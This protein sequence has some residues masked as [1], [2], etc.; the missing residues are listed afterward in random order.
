MELAFQRGRPEDLEQIFALF[1]Q[2]IE[3]MDQNGI[4]Q[5]DEVYPDRATLQGDL[6]EGTL[7]VARE[8]RGATAVFV[9]NGD[10]DE[11]Y[12]NGRWTEQEA[13]LVLHRLCVSPRAQH[14][15]LGRLTVQAAERQAAALGARAL[16]LDV[17]QR[18]PHAL[19]LYEKSGYR[20]V[21]EARFRKGP[22]TLM[23]KTLE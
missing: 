14:R 6:E 22:F 12:A 16:R 8:K 3:E 1:C 5:W 13:F 11:Q 2:A 20:A 19:R 17:F 10:C 9:L 15:G 18:N 7:Y 23:G 4:P 21:G